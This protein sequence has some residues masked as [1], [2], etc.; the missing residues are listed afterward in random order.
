MDRT[1]C[2]QYKP[3]ILLALINPLGWVASLLVSRF[4]NL[5]RDKSVLVVGGIAT[6]VLLGYAVIRY[7]KIELSKRRDLVLSSM[8][9][10]GIYILYFLRVSGVD[11]K[12]EILAGALRFAGGVL[13]SVP[14]IIS[15][16]FFLL[17]LLGKPVNRKLRFIESPF[18]SEWLNKFAA[19]FFALLALIISLCFIAAAIM[20][21]W[22][23][24]FRFTILRYFVATFIC[25]SYWIFL[26]SVLDLRGDVS[27]KSLFYQSV[28]ELYAV[29]GRVPGK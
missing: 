11:P 23:G 10:G 25:F 13:L 16:P 9:L 4:F 14:S 24:Y 22:A 26:G 5:D 15:M 19:R 6:L 29:F 28:T 21:F 3:L 1:K 17:I 7:W 18:E 20:V 2:K 8:I 27:L 12:M